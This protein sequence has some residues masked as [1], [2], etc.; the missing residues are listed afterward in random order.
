MLLARGST[1]AEARRIA[2]EGLNSSELLAELASVERSVRP[3]PLGDEPASDLGRTSATRMRMLRKSPGFTALAVLSLALGIGGNAAMFSVLSAVLIRPL[4]YPDSARLV[5]AANDGYYPPGGLVDLQRESRT[6][7]VAGFN[8]G[9][10]LNLT[11][12]GDA[13]RLEGT[14]VSANLFDVLGAGV[15]LGRGFRPGDDQPGQD[16]LV[17]LSHARMAG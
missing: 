6:M 8:A 4:P 16:N 3:E 7:D 10:D 5:R 13:W 11:G 14:A 12:Q 9:I 2:L 17:I 1:E 15:A